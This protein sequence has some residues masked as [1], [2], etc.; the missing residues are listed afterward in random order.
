MTVVGVG[1]GC[2]MPPARLHSGTCVLAA[3]LNITATTTT[4]KQGLGC[5]TTTQYTSVN[6]IDPLADGYWWGDTVWKAKYL[7][8]H[9]RG[10]YQEEVIIFEDVS[11]VRKR[12]EWY[13]YLTKT[14][15]NE[16]I[17]LV[18]PLDSRNNQRKY[19]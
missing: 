7:P 8:E 14:D 5:C 12:V 15:V 13:R 18:R 11:Y 2:V 6:Y 4:T 10:Y 3:R 9:E 16:Y 19:E 17:L 1:V